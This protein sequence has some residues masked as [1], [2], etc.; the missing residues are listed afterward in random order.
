MV[1]SHTGCVSRNDNIQIQNGVVMCHIPHGMCEQKFLVEMLKQEEA[2]HI[3]HGMCEQKCCV[4]TII[5]LK[6]LGH[7][8]HGMCEQK[9]LDAYGMAVR[10]GHIPHGM[11]EQK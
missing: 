4:N 6:D 1:T 11:C 7:I 9:L 8:P 5:E 3:P 2:S 10:N